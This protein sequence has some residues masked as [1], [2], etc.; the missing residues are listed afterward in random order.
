MVL[1]YL[2]PVLDNGLANLHNARRAWVPMMV[3]FGDHP[4]QHINILQI[5]FAP[6]ESDIAVLAGTVSR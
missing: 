3:V 5:Y 2:D 6:I 1:L 4:T